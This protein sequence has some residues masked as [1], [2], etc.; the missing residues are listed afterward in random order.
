MAADFLRTLNHQERSRMVIQSFI[1][2]CT[3]YNCVGCDTRALPGASDAVSA[4]TTSYQQDNV[5]TRP[6][7][8]TLPPGSPQAPAYS[9]TVPSMTE[10]E[11]DVLFN[12][13]TTRESCGVVTDDNEEEPPIAAAEMEAE[14]KQELSTMLENFRVIH[15]LNTLP[16]VFEIM[17][18][19]S[20]L[21][22]ATQV[23]TQLEQN[24][25]DSNSVIT[26]ESANFTTIVTPQT[27]FSKGVVDDNGVFHELFEVRKIDLCE[28]C[29]LL[30]CGECSVE[31]HFTAMMTSTEGVIT[32][33]NG[34]IERPYPLELTAG[35]EIHVLRASNGTEYRGIPMSYSNSRCPSLVWFALI[36]HCN[37]VGICGNYCMSTGQIMQRCP[38][39]KCKRLTNTTGVAVKIDD[40]WYFKCD[41]MTG[42]PVIYHNRERREDP[43]NIRIESHVRYV[44]ERLT[45]ELEPRLVSRPVT[46]YELFIHN[47]SEIVYGIQPVFFYM[48][49]CLSLR[50]VWFTD[51]G[52]STK[53]YVAVGPCMVTD[54]C[55]LVC[56]CTKC[57]NYRGNPRFQYVTI[58]PREHVM[59]VSDEIIIHTASICVGADENFFFN[60][61]SII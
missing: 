28:C 23:A 26:H 56:T 61:K 48:D 31:V 51:I 22:T 32:A 44:M 3:D 5:E 27:Y 47:T 19:E 41:D 20:S 45:D 35:R 8:P 53:R 4:P 34:V 18:E 55:I 49:E 12:Q 6:F 33:F 43:G 46:V 59:P 14:A 54:S 21:S 13:T 30:C 25:A 24:Q 1:C 10:D 16:R 50:E 60:K 29:D 57:S 52:D 17:P 9:P 37:V 36:N 39:R 7:T 42:N 58:D 2:R 40:I 15:D 11:I 38:C